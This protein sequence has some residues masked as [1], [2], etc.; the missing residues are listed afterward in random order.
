MVH[1]RRG[2]RDG[3]FRLNWCFHAYEG[4]FGSSVSVRYRQASRTLEFLI[5]QKGGKE[6]ILE[7]ELEFKG[8]EEEEEETHADER[9]SA[10]GDKDN[11]ELRDF[12]S[13]F[14]MGSS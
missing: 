3:H 8:I 10:E 7:E 5:S 1:R 13:R 4:A 12:I 2:R 11:G 14:F 9:S 6:T